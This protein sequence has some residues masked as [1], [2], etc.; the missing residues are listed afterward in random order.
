MGF[1]AHLHQLGDWALVV[2]RIGVGAIFLI[3]G[4][5]KQAM[6]KMQ[7]SLQMPASLL[8][9]LKTLSIAE[10]LGALAVL[11]GLLTQLAAAGFCVVMLGA[12][13]LKAVQMHKGFGGEGGWEFEFIILIAALALVLLGAGRF[14]LDRLLFGI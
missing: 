4:R 9:L 2:L 11:S 13:R 7:P 10:P 6:W 3:H 14:A 8:S 5:Q 12:I 1:F